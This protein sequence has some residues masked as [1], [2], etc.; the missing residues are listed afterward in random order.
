[1]PA[2]AQKSI[3]PLESEATDAPLSFDHRG[4]TFTVP[5]PLDYPLAVLE[6]N[7]ELEIVRLVLGDAQWAEYTSTSPTVR[8]FQ[9][10]VEKVNETAG[11]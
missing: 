7:T 5:A 2:A 6:A 11:N 3:A 10:L 1:M 9:A 8:D 4:L